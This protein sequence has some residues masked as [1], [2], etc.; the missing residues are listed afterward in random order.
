M[1]AVMAGFFDRFRGKNADVETKTSAAKRLIALQFGGRASWSPNDMSTL[2]KAGY[3]RNAIANRCV[4]MISEAAAAVPLKASNTQ[5]QKLMDR[6]NPDQSGPE[7]MEAF[8]GFL[9]VAGNAYLEIAELDG[10]PRELFAL[11]PDRMRVLPGARGWPDGWEYTVGGRKCGFVRNGANFRSPILHMKIFHPG[12]DYY[13]YSPMQAASR[14]MD[15]HNAGGEWAKALLDNAAR[16]SGAL[17]FS[18]ADSDG[19]LNDEQFER[20]KQEL[21]EAHTGPTNAG[22]PMLLEGGLDWKPMALSPAEMDFTEARREAA[23]EIALAFGVPPLLLGLPGDNTYANF[24]EAN[25][26][27]WRQTVSPLVTKTARSMTGWLR[28]W[29]GDDLSVE[30]DESAVPALRELME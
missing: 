3:E 30:A 24:R 28:P 7:L 18:S 25:L 1:E 15:L 5:A 21:T 29:F 9:Q 23:R 14:A 13:G 6:P 17:V 16:P 8:F 26:A 4:R 12:D 20:L 27:F 19:R 11:R 2:F 22:R 10:T